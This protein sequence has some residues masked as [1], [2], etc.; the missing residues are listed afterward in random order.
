[1]FDLPSWLAGFT[2]GAFVALLIG[3]MF[4]LAQWAGLP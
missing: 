4:V 2:T 1:M 3:S